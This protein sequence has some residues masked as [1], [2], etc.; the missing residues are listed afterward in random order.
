MKKII[1]LLSIV[2]AFFVSSCTNVANTGQQTPGSALIGTTWSATNNYGAVITITFADANTGSGNVIYG[3]APYATLKFTYSMKDVANGSGALI[4]TT[5]AGKTEVYSFSFIYMDGDLYVTIPDYLDGTMKFTQ[6]NNNQG[7]NQGGNNGG[8]TNS[9][10]GTSW[11]WMEDEADEWV[12]LSFTNATTG[13]FTQYDEGQPIATG[14]FTYTM[15]NETTGT[16]TLYQT[17]MGEVIT[18]QIEFVIVGN[19]MFATI[20]V[21]ATEKYTY[22]FI[23]I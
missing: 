17:Y 15:T 18:Y 23:K 8:T 5:T 2:A 20:H 10:V 6:V 1:L 21:S 11:K 12:I 3:G 4:E 7:A 14:S 22:P 13:T 9:L 19:Q 16:G